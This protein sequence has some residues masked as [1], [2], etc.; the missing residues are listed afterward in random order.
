M[1][2]QWKMWLR[3]LALT[4]PAACCGAVLFVDAASGQNVPEPAPAEAKDAAKDEKDK[5]KDA[6]KDVKDTARD[7]A[8]DVKDARE[9]V[10]DNAKDARE[11]VRDTRGDTR[12]E[13]RDTR[14]DTRDTVRDARG[15]AR[16]A[17][18]DSRETIREKRGEARETNRDAREP[19]RDA[20]G[21]VRDTVRDPRDPK[22]P[23]RDQSRDARDTDNIRTPRVHTDVSADRTDVQAN[24]RPEGVR[25][26]DFGLWFNRNSKDGL[27]ISDV[28]S[29][30]A[31]ANLGFQ[32]GDRIVSVGGQKVTSETDFVTY[33]FD[34]QYRNDRVKVVVLRDGKEQVIMVQPALLIDELSYIDNDPL[35]NFGVVVD[36][37]VNDR[38]V[39]WKVVP[40]SPAY[41]AGIRAGDVLQSV[42]NQRL[43]NIGGL[44]NYLTTGNAS[45]MQLQV[46]RGQATKN[47]TVDLPKFEPR[48]ARR[49]TLRPNFDAAERRDDRIDR[50]EERID[51]RR[52]RIEDRRDNPI[53]P[54]P[55]VNPPAVT[56]APAPATTPAPAQP[57]TNPARRPG[58]FPRR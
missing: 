48:T 10:R 32:E 35:E 1:T 28:A 27:V 50:R 15:T 3:P 12:E 24:F 31:I 5:A 21:E 18:Q 56:P 58:L 52:D 39:V 49:T 40:R 23:A 4:L 25:S 43:A 47:I 19:V 17:R 38:I 55:R 41:Y 11:T 37:R 22:N 57:N 8:K 16:E 2:T 53:I 26:A 45:Q 20:R 7:K 54:A 6:E 51:S 33:L 30:G 14:Q 34:E 13:I 42:G 36:D 29:K 46:G 9:N 44:V